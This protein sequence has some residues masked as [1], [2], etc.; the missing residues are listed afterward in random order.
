MTDTELLEKVKKAIGVGGTYHDETLMIYIDEVKE[1]MLAAGINKNIVNGRKVLGA[2]CR[3]VLDLWNYGSG[4]TTLSNY[5]MQ[6][7]IQLSLDQDTNYE[8]VKT[9][10]LLANGYMLYTSNEAVF[11]ANEEVETNFLLANEMILHTSD[12]LIFTVKR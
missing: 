10:F 12:E 11:A 6:R 7:V 9:N 1:Y 8:E 3:G 5:F 4:N 2:I